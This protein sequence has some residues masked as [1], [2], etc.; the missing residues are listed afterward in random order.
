MTTFNLL[1]PVSA[2]DLVNFV[3]RSF[4]TPIVTK[5]M[6]GDAPAEASAA[7]GAGVALRRADVARVVALGK[8][9]GPDN[10]INRMEE[11]LTFR[12]IYFD[13][14]SAPRCT[15]LTTLW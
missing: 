10:K 13:Q 6:V 9:G 5:P 4:R 7:D 11:M 3:V 1:F 14:Y 2:F 12:F 8:D 15:T